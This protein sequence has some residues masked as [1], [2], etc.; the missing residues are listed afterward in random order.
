MNQGSNSK[1]PLNNITP[2]TFYIAKTFNIKL[3][4][5]KKPEI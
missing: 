5:I 4:I 3:S 1:Q 2:K